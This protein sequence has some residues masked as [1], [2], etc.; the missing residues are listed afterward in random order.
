MPAPNQHLFPGQTSLRTYSGEARIR[1]A[2]SR[3]FAV[4]SEYFHYSYDFGEGAPRR[5]ALASP[6]F[7]SSAASG[8]GSRSSVNRSDKKAG[9]A[10]VSVRK[11]SLNEIASVIAQRRWLILV[12]FAFGVALA[13]FLARYAPERY[14]SEALIV[15]IPQQVPDNYVKPT[16]S[17]SVEERL[18]SITDQILSRSRLERII[19]EMDLYKAE[20]ARESWRM[21]SR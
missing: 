19:Q 4:Y 5:S 16:V 2:L 11:Y 20:R 12:P 8:W 6:A 1:Y 10:D 18:P 15:V 7:T 17:E 13:P 14:R 3:T 21:S 9:T